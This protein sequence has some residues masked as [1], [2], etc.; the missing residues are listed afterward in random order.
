MTRLHR[1]SH[2]KLHTHNANLYNARL[3]G[4]LLFK[5]ALVGIATEMTTGVRPLLR[6]LRQHSHKHKTSAEQTD[7]NSTHG[8]V[9]LNSNYTWHHRS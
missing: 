7:F 5:V 9:A 4:L 6:Y 3:P 1:R 2:L 8:W